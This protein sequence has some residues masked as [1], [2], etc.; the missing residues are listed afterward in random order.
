[1]HR[2]M[3]VQCGNCL[4]RH[5]ACD[6]IERFKSGRR[7]FKHAEGARRPSTPITD[8]KTERVRDTI[9]Q[10]RRVAIGEVAYQLQN[11]HGSAYEIIRRRLASH[12]VSARRVPGQLKELHEKNHLDICKRFLDSYAVEVDH[13]LERIVTE[14]EAWVHHYEPESKCQSGKCEHAHSPVKRK[15]KTHRTVGKLILP[16]FGDSQGLLPVYYQERVQ[17]CTVLADVG[18]CVTS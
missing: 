15:I 14:D 18:C 11:S 2:R 12:K 17:Q 4:L 8:T 10:N 5:I 1:M 7:S 9:L 3:S 16:V 6:L 13:F